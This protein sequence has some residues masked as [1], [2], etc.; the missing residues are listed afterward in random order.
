[1]REVVAWLRPPKHLWHKSSVWRNSYAKD[2]PAR[3][4]ERAR[5][6]AINHE[7]LELTAIS[8]RQARTARRT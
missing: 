2:R 7:I 6:M 5:Q 4:A 3:R 1:T 8:A